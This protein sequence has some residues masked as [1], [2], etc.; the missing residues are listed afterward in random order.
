[1]KTYTQF[2]NRLR[3]VANVPGQRKS[4]FKV[5]KLRN[6]SVVDRPKSPAPRPYVSNFSEDMS[7]VLGLNDSIA[8][9]AD[10]YAIPNHPQVSG[11]SILSQMTVIPQ[12]GL[13]FYQSSPLTCVY[14]DICVEDIV[15]RFVNT[16]RIDPPWETITQH[17]SLP[18]SVSSDTMIYLAQ[19][20]ERGFDDFILQKW[21]VEIQ[22]KV[23]YT[24]RSLHEFFEN[25]TTPTTWHVVCGAARI[26]DAEMFHRRWCSL[27]PDL[28]VMC[29]RVV[30]VDAMYVVNSLGYIQRSATT[31]FS[32]PST[33]STR[34]RQR[35]RFSLEGVVGI[36]I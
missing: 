21:G 35:F 23:D 18:P 33:M 3:F 34:Y 20:V 28:F 14:G 31:D 29:S 22:D 11:V 24:T 9:F 5:C 16:V 27:F 7:Q 4:T 6:V 2:S 10:E 15:D 1:M 13:T 26:A 32:V 25:N 17:L 12:G 30:P 8:N 36:S 19:H